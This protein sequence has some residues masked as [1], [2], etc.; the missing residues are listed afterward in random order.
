M[1]RITSAVTTTAEFQVS[2]LYPATNVPGPVLARVLTK[3]LIAHDKVSDLCVDMTRHAG[4]DKAL[5][6][7]LDKELAKGWG[8]YLAQSTDTATFRPVT[9]KSSPKTWSVS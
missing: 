1:S 2:S 4:T 8:M 7:N 5:N 3:A 9:Y 6:K